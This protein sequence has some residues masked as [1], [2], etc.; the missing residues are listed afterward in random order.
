MGFDLS[1]RDLERLKGVD[2]RL[3]NVV[4][5]AA[6]LSDV[7]FMVV[8]GVRTRE[9]CM[10]NYGKGRTAAQLAVHR[11]P[12]SYA[13]PGA[14]KVTWLANPFASKH[15]DGRAVDLLVEP[16]DWKTPGK[17]AQL[18]KAM[19]AAANALGVNMQWGGDWKKL[20]LPH[21]EI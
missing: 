18:G 21:F 5:K 15:C 6:E 16:Y 19:K 12:A 11:I 17:W 20:D 3:V 2:Q 7:K 4:K 10:V 9:R 8:E 1:A 13:Q 14:A